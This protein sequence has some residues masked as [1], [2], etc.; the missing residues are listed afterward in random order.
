MCADHL[1]SILRTLRRESVVE[2]TQRNRAVLLPARFTTMWRSEIRI[3]LKIDA[4]ALCWR[5]RRYCLRRTV[6]RA[7]VAV[8]W[9]LCMRVR[10][11]K[12]EEW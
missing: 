1:R 2:K 12:S 8:S 11:I 7:M 9:I 3:D 5:R 4:E 6:S 10:H